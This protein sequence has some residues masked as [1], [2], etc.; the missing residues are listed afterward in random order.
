MSEYS[1]N[2]SPEKVQIL[3]D[4]AR[5]FLVRKIDD[6]IMN[7]FD[8]TSFV[9]TTDWLTTDEDSE[10]KLA[11]KAFDDGRLQILLISKHTEDGRRT[12]RKKP[13]T[14]EEYDTLLDTSVLRLKK[15]RHEFEY[16]QAGVAY[17]VKLDEFADSTLS[18]LEVD[19]GNESDRLAFDPMTFPAH[20]NEV[21]GTTDYYGYRIA[22]VV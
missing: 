7:Q 14:Q 11:H 4:D 8:V 15:K 18:I 20:L 13:I 6:T 17:D 12:S 10:T 16:A 22:G 1:Q 9:M 19:A 2:T 5:K 21:T 3:E